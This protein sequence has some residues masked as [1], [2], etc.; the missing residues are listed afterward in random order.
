MSADDSIATAEKDVDRTVLELLLHSQQWPWSIEE[1]G[2]ELGD[3]PDAEDALSRLSR[4]GLVHRH[5]RFVFPSRA[6][7]RAVEL[8]LAGR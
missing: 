6:A 8:D 4:V 5:D 1:V 2:R 7:I 3:L